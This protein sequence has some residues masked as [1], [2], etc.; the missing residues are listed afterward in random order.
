[1]PPSIFSL[2]EPCLNRLQN[3]LRMPEPRSMCHTV[4]ANTPV[5][6]S[7]SSEQQAG[8]VHCITS[9]QKKPTSWLLKHI[10]VT[11]FPPPTRSCMKYLC[12]RTVTHTRHDFICS[13]QDLGFH[14]LIIS[15]PIHSFVVMF[16]LTFF[17]YSS[18]YSSVSRWDDSAASYL[19]NE[20]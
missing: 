6:V 2:E 3:K 20:H 5:L 12:T 8:G 1:M 11:S 19:S 13:I 10:L 17:T 14:F 9:F 15:Y 16:C 7:T 4:T 18:T